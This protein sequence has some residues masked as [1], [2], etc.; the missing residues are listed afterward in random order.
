MPVDPNA[1]IEIS[2]FNWVP[3]FA[4][5]VVRD[6]RVRWALEEIGLPYRVRLLSP[7]GDKPQDYL[8]EQPF[9]QVPVFV[10][11]A[12]HLFESGAI[13]LHLGERSEAL[14]PRD[15]AGKARATCWL[16]AALN[17]IEPMMFELVNIDVFNAGAAWANERRPEAERTV[18][19][20]LQ[21]L[22]D[23]LGDHEHLEGRF[24]VADLMMTTVLRNLRHT[25]IIADYPNL[26]AY[27]ARCE[28]RPAFGR[29]LAAQ[30][31]DFQDKPDAPRAA[32]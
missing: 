24:T 30:L 3:D 27:Q 28:A 21:R 16:I 15:S 11:G 5:G 32:A 18:R 14:L 17:S 23:W 7:M 29:A 2:A 8:L 19:T 1:A 9:G 6:L 10:E 12:L 13:L 22:S 20:R 31:A 4:K 26:A 25:S